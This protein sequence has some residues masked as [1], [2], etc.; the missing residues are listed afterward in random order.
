[1]KI[2]ILIVFAAITF[3]SFFSTAHAGEPFFGYVYTTDTTPAGRWELEQWITDREGQANGHFHHFHFNTE[4]EYGVTDAFQVA[5]YTNFMYDN[6]NKNSVAGRTEGIEIPY[7]HD[8]NTPYNA[9][10]FDGVSMEFLYRL[11][12]P[13]T[14]PLGLAVYLEPE[15]GPIERG[16]EFRTILQKNFMDDQLVLALNGWIEFEKEKG[17]N[18]VTPGSTDT[19]DGAWAKATMLEADL[20]ASYRVAPGW[21]VGLEFRNHNEYAGW[22]LSS[23]NQDHTAF[24]LGPNVHYA[25]QH[26]FFTLTVLRQL[27][28][29]AYNDDQRAQMQGGLLYGDE[30]TTWDGIRL[31]VGF[32]F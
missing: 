28:A 26:W 17:S 27:A 31:K 24:F 11:L 4:V 8:P 9:F 14:D 16:L 1:M 18:L 15:V 5:L 6:D 32:P 3:A 21:F 22:T 30:H 7:D 13:Y 25:S 12:S 20:G 19:P 29:V 10:R 2:S 23:N